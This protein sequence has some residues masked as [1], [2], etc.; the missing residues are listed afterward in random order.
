MRLIRPTHDPKKT[1]FIERLDDVRRIFLALPEPLNVAY[2]IGA[3]AGLRTGEVFA[4][5]WTHVD[6][7]ARRIHVRE[8]VNGPLKDGD[9]RIVPVLDALLPILTEWKLKSGGAGRVI[10]P[11]RCDGKKIDKATPGNYLRAALEQL[12]LTQPGLGWYEATRHTFPS[13]WVLSGNSIEKLS[14]ILGHYSVVMTR[15]AHLR[16]VLF[17]QADLA[18]IAVDLRKSGA[19]VG[20]LGHRMAT[21]L[22]KPTANHAEE[23]ENGRSRPVSRV[24]SP[25][26]VAEAGEADIPLGPALP[27]ASSELTR[28][29][30]GPP[31]PLEAALPYLLLLRVGL[32]VPPPSPAARCALAAPFHPCLPFGRRSVLCGAVPRVASAGR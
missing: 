26:P 1:P 19:K 14:A 9:S 15:Y 27:R 3:L 5:R 7:A 29:H 11:M 23:E 18:T 4:L 2:A 10:P 21:D 6:L 12:E 28:E 22:L 31:L 32:A 30:G 25:R 8:S 13:Q 17:T 24:L 16:P 20:E